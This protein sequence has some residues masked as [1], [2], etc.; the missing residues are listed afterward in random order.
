[1]TNHG[2]AFVWLDTEATCQSLGPWLDLPCS[3][4]ALKLVNSIITLL[5]LPI[6]HL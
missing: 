1:M 6:Q 5:V 4:S 3:P 2:V